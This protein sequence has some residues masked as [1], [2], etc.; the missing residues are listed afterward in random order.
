MCV[1]GDNLPEAVCSIIDL[2]VQILDTNMASEILVTAIP[3]HILNY[4]CTKW[5]TR[6]HSLLTVA[7]IAYIHFCEIVRWWGQN[8]IYFITAMVISIV[9]IALAVYTYLVAAAST[10]VNTFEAERASPPW[11][12]ED[13]IVKLS[14]G[15]LVE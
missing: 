7:S 8:P 5:A 13:E 12:E 15:F 4:A 2:F 11:T 10:E 1:F 14:T 3:L 6:H 9:S